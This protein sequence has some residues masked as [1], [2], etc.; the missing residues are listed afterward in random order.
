MT[1]S[2]PNHLL[3]SQRLPLIQVN[4]APIPHKTNRPCQRSLCIHKNGPKSGPQIALHKQRR[5]LNP[6]GIIHA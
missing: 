5:L 1:H 2:Y 6:T 3:Q 4:Q